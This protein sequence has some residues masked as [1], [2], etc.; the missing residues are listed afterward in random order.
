MHRIVLSLSLSLEMC[1]VNV[2][3]RKVPW[4]DYNNGQLQLT[5]QTLFAMRRFAFCSDRF[6]KFERSIFTLPF[7]YSLIWTSRILHSTENEQQ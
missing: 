5:I 6:P 1:T 4:F 7:N 3:L 2:F